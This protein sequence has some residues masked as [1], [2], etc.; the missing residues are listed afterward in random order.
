MRTMR[1]FLVVVGRPM[2]Y[3]LALSGEE[4]YRIE[5]VP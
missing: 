2:M 1:L 3:E 4:G 5:Q